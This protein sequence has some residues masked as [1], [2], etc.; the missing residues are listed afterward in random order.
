MTWQCLRLNYIAFEF[1]QAINLR[2]R[3]RPASPAGWASS[4][5]KFLRGSYPKGKDPLILVQISANSDQAAGSA[6][7]D[8]GQNLKQKED[9]KIG[10]IEIE[11]VGAGQIAGQLRRNIPD[12]WV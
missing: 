9:N 11:Q 10:L 6:Q 1:A 5:N 8:A 3:L 4:D 2:F 12:Q 7:R